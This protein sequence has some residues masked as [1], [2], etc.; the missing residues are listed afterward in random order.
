[1]SILRALETR[2]SPEN[3]STSLAN[4]A[5]WF[6]DWMGGGKTNAGPAVNNQ[7]ALGLSAVYAA[8]RLI[9][10]TIATL[11]LP[12]YER[13]D[14]GKRRDPSHRLYS[15]LH[16]RPNPEMSSV[17]FWETLASHSVGWGNG[18]AEIQ[19]DGAGRTVGLWPLLP[20][21]TEP[22]R[23]DGRKVYRT[24]IGSEWVFL[25]ADRVL[26]IPGLGFDG[27]KGY[28]PITLHRQSLGLALAAEEYG[29]RYFSN[30]S[31][32]S[33]VLTTESALKDDA[34]ARLKESW[35][36]AH[37]G[38]SN[39]HR[40]IILEAGMDWKQ[41]SIP[42]E[43]AQF[44]E[45]RKYQNADIARIMRVPLALLEE[46]DKAAS[47]NSVEQ[48]M[49][50]FLMHSIRPWLVRFEKPINH[51]LF[52]EAE[53]RTHFAEFLVDGLLR[54]DI[55]S[56]SEA[57]AVQ[58]Q[59]GII[60][61]DEWRELENMNPQ[62]D[63]QGEIYL[64]NGNMISVSAAAEAMPAGNPALAAPVEDERAAPAAEART[65]V[66]LVE[67]RA[68]RSIE[69]RRLQREVF[70]DVF[71]TEADRIVRSEVKAARA[72]LKKSAGTRDAARFRQWLDEYYEQHGADWIKGMAPLFRA[73]AKVVQAAAADEVGAPQGV[74]IELTR[75][76]DEYVDTFA[77][78]QVGSS[79]GQLREILRD[80]SPEEVEAALE[81]RLAEWEETR[82]AKIGS[83]ESH[84]AGNAF[85]VEAYALAGVVTLRWAT[86]GEDCSICRRL[87]GRTVAIRTPFLG[88]GDVVDP[89]DGVTAPLVTRTV[90]KHP[91]LHKGCNCLV[92]AA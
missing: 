17:T 28:N 33:G 11:P 52:T 86:I 37:S 57:L 74:T 5:A 43:E 23:R 21:R 73:Y 61:A 77:A 72:A 92:V 29:A 46:H 32:A 78:R 44:L 6:T 34:Y 1:M 84:R 16:D 42:P 50:S 13:L 76:T 7:S 70:E 31:R 19:V 64:V 59:N 83:R 22:V 36:N 82:A 90:I 45:T 89:D 47:Y 30:G 14:R 79:A 3:P 20:D 40:A 69:G 41:T 24:R 12:V 49:L 75:F 81:Q 35:A 62:P 80:V 26:H 10:E 15:V 38:L 85:A 48:F 39:S 27:L 53:R 54:G 87:E 88:E 8:I 55:K 51:D 9:A 65:V 56:R 68:Q 25:N 18:Y 91:P 67:Y 2:A 63:G 4:P 66:D 60:N 58:R 71:R